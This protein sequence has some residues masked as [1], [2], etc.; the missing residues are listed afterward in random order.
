MNGSIFGQPCE[1]EK[2]EKTIKL[3]S[4]LVCVS[5]LATVMSMFR[6]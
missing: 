5:I 3:E 1:V 4:I 6:R 2:L